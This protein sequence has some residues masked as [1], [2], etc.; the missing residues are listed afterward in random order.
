MYDDLPTNP[1]NPDA[2]NPALNP[3]AG[4]RAAL[5]RLHQQLGDSARREAVIFVGW[6]ESGKT[7]LLRHFN[8]VFDDNFLGVYVPV[9][10]APEDE[11]EWLL[12]LARSVTAEIVER[13]YT[14][15]RLS[16]LPPPED[17]AR[18]W[19]TETFLGEIT[20][21]LRPHRRLVFLFDNAER[22]LDAIASG[23][24]PADHPAFLAEML[25]KLPLTNL[26]MTFDAARESE[27]E[28]LGALNGTVVQRL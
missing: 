16:T 22:L 18:A 28:A 15:H 10:A 23:R 25:E 21:I 13:G 11:A 14:L 24:L 27:L 3:F 17:D 12:T 1:Y 6:R 20:A 5:A 8:T 9:D 7:A 19:F 4:R 2:D 26:V